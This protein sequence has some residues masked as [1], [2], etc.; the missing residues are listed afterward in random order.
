MRFRLIVLLASCCL[1]SA[2]LG[3]EPA[4]QILGESAQHWQGELSSPSPPRRHLAAW[5]LS[6]L[7]AADDQSLAAALGHRDP[8]VRYWA[9]QGMLRQAA[10]QN[11]DQLLPLLS[12]ESRSVRVAAAEGCVRV[13]RDEG[14]K[15]LAECLSDPQEA[16]RIQA[17]T[18]L[19]RLGPQA[20][21]LK[22]SIAN[23]TSDSSEYV[24]RIS[25]RL[26]KNLP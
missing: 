9:V 15:V 12:D 5:A 23:G 19:E 7:A 10:V 18:S 16:V 8:V 4:A 6:Q 2:A 21:P 14:L 25:T 24:K 13:G 22:V 11:A 26:L 17:I 20:A 1:S 3:A